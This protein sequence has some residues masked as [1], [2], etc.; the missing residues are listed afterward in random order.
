VRQILE[1]GLSPPANIIPL[2][3][4]ARMVEEAL[5][6]YFPEAH[7]GDGEVYLRQMYVVMKALEGQGGDALRTMVGQ[8][9]DPFFPPDLLVQPRH[10]SPPE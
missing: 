10:K 9:V 4:A 7:L 6:K 3:T 8:G 2:S 1:R 5:H